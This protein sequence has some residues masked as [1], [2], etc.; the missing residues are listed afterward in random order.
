MIACFHKWKKYF[1][2]TYDGR[3]GIKEEGVEC[4]A[5]TAKSVTKQELGNEMERKEEA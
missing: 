5:I 1:F 4:Y 3:V 2:W